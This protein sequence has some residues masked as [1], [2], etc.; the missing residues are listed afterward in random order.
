M[1]QEKEKE[2]KGKRANNE[3]RGDEEKAEEGRGKAKTI[4]RGKGRRGQRVF[5][6]T[7]T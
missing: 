7:R 2:E 5:T 6:V 4:M 3:E 1:K